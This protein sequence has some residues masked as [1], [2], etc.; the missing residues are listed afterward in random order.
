[1]WES[2]RRLFFFFQKKDYLSLI[3]LGRTRMGAIEPE[4]NQQIINDA[5]WI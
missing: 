5:T 4:K 2:L 1:M 3:G